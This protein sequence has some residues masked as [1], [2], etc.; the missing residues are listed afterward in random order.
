[1]RLGYALSRVLKIRMED[2]QEILKTHNVVAQH[3][4]KKHFVFWKCHL[5]VDR[6][7]KW[8]WL[9]EVLTV[10]P[11]SSLGVTDFSCNARQAMYFFF[12]LP[13]FAIEK[14]FA[15]FGN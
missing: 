8:F 4:T 12:F 10:V 11:D 2:F 13:L 1:M 3:V 7:G 9:T 14:M 15:I 5:K 6:L